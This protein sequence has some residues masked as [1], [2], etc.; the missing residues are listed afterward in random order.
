MKIKFFRFF[1]FFT[2]YL[3]PSTFYLYSE[4]P[5]GFEVYFNS[6][7]VTHGLKDSSGLDFRFKNFI[8]AA[9]DKTIYAA[10]YQI[11]NSTVVAALNAALNRGCTVYVI[12]DDNDGN[13]TEYGQLNTVNKKLGNSSAIMHN[14]FCVIEGSSVWTGSWNATDNG[15]Y[16]NNN[17][18]IVLRSIAIAEIYEKEFKVMWGGT[19]DGVDYGTAKFGSYK[20]T[21]SYG[22]NNNGQ[23]LTVNGVKVKIYFSPYANPKRTNTAII[24]EIKGAGTISGAQEKLYFCLFNF[25][26]DDIGDNIADVIKK[27]INV[28]GIFDLGQP[29][30]LTE[31][32][33][34]AKLNSAGAS[35]VVDGSSYKLHHKFAVIDPFT[36][37]SKVITG[38][39]NWSVA[40]NKD[41]DE[42][43]LIIYS[44]GIAK[45][46]YEEFQK[47]YRQAGPVTTLLKKAV[48]EV[49]VY[50]SPA[51]GKTTIG[52]ELSSNVTN[53]IVKIYTLSGKVV[54]ELTLSITPGVYNE[55]TWNC[56]NDNGEKVAS[57][58]YILKVEATTADKTFFVTEKFA[59]IKGEK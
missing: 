46:Y 30:G 15:T 48:G 24:N 14:K 28:T 41:N 54:K 11:N 42:N 10:F 2:L 33:E 8:D 52:F 16:Q 31:D 56:V 6:H 40:A 58:L 45:V 13:T 59:V 37:N 47:L 26:D 19:W 35:V 4:I 50:P 38:S 7:T 49:V 29:S 5:P 1:V 23:E 55:V 3:L 22:K 20:N 17:N 25:S 44:T 36:S 34:Y 12:S 39:H 57:G 9:S 27:G 21:S 53:V 43:T 51:R 32:S 18:T